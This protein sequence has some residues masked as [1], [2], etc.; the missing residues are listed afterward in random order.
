MNPWHSA[1]VT[2]LAGGNQKPASVNVH[3]AS[4]PCSLVRASAFALSA[5]AESAASESPHALSVAVASYYV[6]WRAAINKHPVGVS[7]ANASKWTR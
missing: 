6:A 5:L 4:V 7:A 2:S 3:P 1:A